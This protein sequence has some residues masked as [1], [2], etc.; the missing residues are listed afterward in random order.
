MEWCLEHIHVFVGT[1]WWGSIVLTLIGVRMFL[2]KSYITASDNTARLATIRPHI[3]GLQD[4]MKESKAAKDV[5]GT[6]KAASELKGIY[7]AAGIKLWKNFVPLIQVPLGYGM[8]RLM[9]NMVSLPV[10]GFEDGGLLWIHDLTV[11]DVTLILPITTALSTYYMFKVCD[12][13]LS[14]LRKANKCFS[15]RRRARRANH[16]PYFIQNIAL[17]DADLF[18][19]IYALLAGRFTA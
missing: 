9:R 16:E 15:E 6:M 12:M 8:F 4:R 10:P 19:S 1:P 11:A 18:P 7:A 3:Q 14:I 17:R 5:H 2:L 13:R